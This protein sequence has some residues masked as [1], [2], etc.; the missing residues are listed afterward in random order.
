MSVELAAYRYG[1]APLMLK[2]IYMFYSDICT[3]HKD[4]FFRERLAYFST[5]MLNCI[6]HLSTQHGF[7]VDEYGC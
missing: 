2:G 6:L 5:T 1:K 4:V 7:K 3:H